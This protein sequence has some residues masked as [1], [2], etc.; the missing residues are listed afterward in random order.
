MDLKF[1]TFRLQIA[2]KINTCH[3]L[4]S[5]V[6]VSRHNKGLSVRTLDC[7]IITNRK[8]DLL[9]RKFCIEKVLQYD[10]IIV[11]IQNPF[12]QSTE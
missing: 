3:C 7:F 8:I 10:H 6:H 2:N 9:Y 11:D 4:V 12:T 5:F 1:F